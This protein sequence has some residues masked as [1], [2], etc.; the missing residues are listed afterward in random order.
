[1]ARDIFSCEKKLVAQTRRVR[2]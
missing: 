2:C 1:M